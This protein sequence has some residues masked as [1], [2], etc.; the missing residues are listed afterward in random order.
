[1]RDAYVV[2]GRL[3]DRW[4]VVTGPN[5]QDIQYISTDELV[6]NEWCRLYNL[7]VKH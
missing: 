1:M 2:K 7:G 5:V 3:T 6:A 4:F